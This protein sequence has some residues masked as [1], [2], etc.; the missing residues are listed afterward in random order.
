MR[1]AEQSGLRLE[2]F[3]EGQ[4]DVVKIGATDY[5]TVKDLPGVSIHPRTFMDD[6]LRPQPYG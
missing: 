4:S 5:D 6:R 3:L 1:Y 2:N